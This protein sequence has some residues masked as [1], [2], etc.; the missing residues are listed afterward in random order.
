MMMFNL[1]DHVALVTG[2]N[3]GLG[4]AMARG[5][6]KAGASVAIWG[7][8]ADKNAAAV[9]EL[10]AMGGKAAAFA[11]DVTDRASCE[12]AF[13]ATIGHFGKIDSCFA[14]AGGSGVR[15]PFHKLS[16]ADWAS[17]NAINVASVITSFQLAVAHWLARKAPGKLI[18]TSSIA[19]L[20]G[21]PQSTGY[22]MTKAAVQ[23]LIRALAIEYG[24]AGI[25]ANAILPG[26]IETEMSLDTPQYF[27]DSCKR[28][29]ASGEIGQ[30]ED[31][32]GIAVYLA[33]RESR[34]MTGQCIV[35]DGGHTIFP[36]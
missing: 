30:L 28:R 2:G 27:Q 9:V 16:D 17:T 11:C 34:F 26:F 18:V 15:G 3:G 12:T 4:L 25:Q 7:R 20:M 14:N 33:S 32:E 31:M 6:V 22:S 1:S 21:I 29:A 8:N 10:T 36:L 23:G 19:G 24:R 5:L 35:L 13:A